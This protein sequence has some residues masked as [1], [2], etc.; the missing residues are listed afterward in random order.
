M[1]EAVT[2]APADPDTIAETE[3]ADRYADLFPSRIAMAKLRADHRRDLEKAHVNKCERMNNILSGV[4]RLA[5][6]G[7]RVSVTQDD[8]R[9]GEINHILHNI[10]EMR[11]I[12]KALGRWEITGKDI[13]DAGRAMIWVHI[14]WKQWPGICFKFEMQL[15]PGGPCQIITESQP[16][17]VSTYL[18][19]S[20]E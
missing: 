10:A 17:Y 15:P 7:Y 2:S 8:L 19:C 4:I 9:M 3:T 16:A 18:A 5:D 13:K 1:T 14:G 11:L 6:A 12:R 20:T